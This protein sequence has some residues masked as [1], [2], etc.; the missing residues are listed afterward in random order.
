MHPTA[1]LAVVLLATPTLSPA[2]AQETPLDQRTAGG[3]VGAKVYALASTGWTIRELDRLEDRVT[4]IALGGGGGLGI[5]V[6][7]DFSRRVAGYAEADLSAEQEGV[8]GSYAVGGLLRTA[9]RGSL[10]FHARVGGRIINLVTSLPYADLGTGGELF[11]T[12]LLALGLDFSATLPIGN[13]TRN[14][15][16]RAVE[17]SP[18][19]GP[20]RFS[21]GLAWYPQY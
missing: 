19:G 1:V 20:R 4:D 6:S 12:P 8:Y 2:F 13:G 16:T 5:R 14:T 17:I 9:D 11:V 7:Y 10:R 15:G 18:R 21:F 3:G